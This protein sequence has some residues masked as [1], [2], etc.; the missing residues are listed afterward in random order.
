MTFVLHLSSQRCVVV[1]MYQQTNNTCPASACVCIPAF[2]KHAS[3]ALTR[4]QKSHALFFTIL[5]IRS[6]TGDED[7]RFKK[8]KNVLVSLRFFNDERKIKQIIFSLK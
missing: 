6:I 1:E 2:G 5:Y 8:K 3:L 4:Q 7:F